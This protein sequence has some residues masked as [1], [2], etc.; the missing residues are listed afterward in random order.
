MDYDSEASNATDN[1]A[2]KM[3]ASLKEQKRLQKKEKE[4]SED[5]T[6]TIEDLDKCYSKCTS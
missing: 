4:E 5:M 1:E 3:H 6:E 2:R